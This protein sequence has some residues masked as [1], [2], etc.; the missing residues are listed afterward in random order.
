MDCRGIVEKYLR[1]NNFDGLVCTEI[2]CGC[3]FKDELFACGE[4]F[5]DCVPAI[6]IKSKCED[7]NIRAECYDPD[8]K[9]KWCYKKPKN[10]KKIQGKKQ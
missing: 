1:D 9:D 8:G 4:N 2:P 7:C 6:A 10:I 3:G 5:C